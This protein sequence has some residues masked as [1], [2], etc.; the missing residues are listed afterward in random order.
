MQSTIRRVEI[1]GG[2]LRVRVADVPGTPCLLVHG[3][4]GGTDYLFKFFAGPVAHAGMQP[5]SFIQR[6]SPGSPSDGPFTIDEMSRDIERVREALGLESVAIVAHSFGCLLSGAWASTR[7]ARVRRLVFIAPVGPR[8]G[9][10][11]AF[12]EELRSRLTGE[13]LQRIAALREQARAAAGDAAEYQRLKFEIANIQVRGY[14]APAYRDSQPGLAE[15]TI[16]VREAAL[17]DLQRWQQDRAW[18][19]GLRAVAAPAHVIHGEQDPIPSF[20]AEQWAEMVPGMRQHPLPTCGHFPWFEDKG[21]FW[22][23]FEDAIRD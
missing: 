3:G 23:A 6:G 2:A 1:P 11:E 14:Y 18:E 21:A 22:E 13:E 19:A 10:R 7:P 4:P 16:R 8:A 17:Q 12:E 20:V 15:L 9:W 5:I